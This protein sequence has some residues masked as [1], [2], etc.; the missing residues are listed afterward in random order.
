M[1][2][3]STRRLVEAAGAATLGVVFAGAVGSAVGVAVPAAVIGGLN[4]AISGWRR[5]YDWRCSNGLVAFTLDSTWGL[6]MT[7]AG[8]VA[9]SVGLLPPSSGYVPELSERHN[10]HV[11][12]GGFRIRKGFAVTL[13]NVVSQAGDIERPRRARLVTDHEDVHVW[14]ARWFGPGYPVLY[15]GWMVF[16][17]AGGAIRWGSDRRKHGDR[18]F[19][20]V[21]SAAYYLNPFEWWAYSRDDYWPPSGKVADFGWRGPCCAPLTIARPERPSGIAQISH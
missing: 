11:Y 21:E 17:G 20:T 18:L 2:S 9:Q 3:D 16:G 8:L 4:G 14:Q 13:G 15:V 7:G 5:T 19:A 6:P 1:F 10:R 12:R